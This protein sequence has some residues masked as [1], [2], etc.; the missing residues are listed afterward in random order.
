MHCLT[1]RLHWG[2]PALVKHR[3]VAELQVC[4]CRAAGPGPEL[5]RERE[6]LGDRH[7]GPYHCLVAKG[8]S[9][10]LKFGT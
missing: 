2:A 3:P 1:Q 8:G 4:V 6:A 5:L 9:S 10:V 7:M